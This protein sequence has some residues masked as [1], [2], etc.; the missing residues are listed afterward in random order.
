MAAGH[1]ATLKAPHL[2]NTGQIVAGH[3][4]HIINSAKLENTGRVDARNDIALDVEDFTN[5]GSPL[6]RA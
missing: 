3:D 2:R 5:T 6:R 1:D 4:I